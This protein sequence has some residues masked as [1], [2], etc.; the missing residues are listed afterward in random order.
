MKQG[1]LL[2]LFFLVHSVLLAQ[3][4]IFIS[5]GAQNIAKVEIE[6]GNCSKQVVVN[7]STSLSDITLHPNGKMYGVGFGSRKVYEVNMTNGSLAELFTITEADKLVGMTAAKDGTIYITEGNVIPS[8]LY[9]VDVSNNT[10]SS[11]GW[12]ADGSAGDLS[13]YFGNLYN[14]SDNNKLV[15]VNIN[16][17]ANSTVIGSF[18]GDLG[19]ERIFALVT[20]VSGC[21]D[22]KTYGFSQEGN[23]FELNMATAQVSR[24]CDDGSIDLFGATSADEFDASECFITLDLDENDNSGVTGNNFD[25]DFICQ[26]NRNA[27]VADSDVKI[28]VANSVDSVVVSLLSGVLNGV[29]EFFIIGSAPN[30]NSNDSSSILTGINSGSATTGNFE[31]FLNTMRFKNLALP[32]SAGTRTV[33]V[34]AYSEGRSDT[35]FTTIDIIDYTNAGTSGSA[36]FCVNDA[37]R[38]LITF[39]GDS[40]DMGGIWQPV[41][42]S[43][44]GVFDPAIDMSGIYTYYVTD[45]CFIDSAEV[46][47]SLANSNSFDLGNDT[48]ICFA[49]SYIIDADIGN[50]NASYVWNTGSTNSS[51][52][53]TTDGN[54]SVTIDLGGCQVQ[55]DIDI[56]F[57]SFTLELG[58]DISICP[59]DTVLIGQNIGIQGANYSWNNGETTDE[60]Y[61]SVPGTYT[62]TAEYQTCTV[63]DMIT[64]NAATSSNIPVDLGSDTTICQGSTLILNT[65]YSTSNYNHMWSDGSTNESLSITTSGTYSVTVSNDCASGTGSVQVIVDDCDTTIIPIDTIDYNICE[66]LMP[67]AFSPNGDNIN[68]YFGPV[69]ECTGFTNYEIRIYNRFGELVFS[70][71]NAI[72]DGT[73]KGEQAPMDNFIWYAVF[74]FSESEDVIESGNIMLL[75]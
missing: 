39:L 46:N 73:Y 21:D 27:L 71:E 19:G 65:G 20:T 25:S 74:H 61:V 53:V 16:D 62:L 70:G 50:P 4:E 52:S 56:E 28:E 69:N 75:R 47:V 41:L 44:T 11:N 23:Y 54:F 1:A 14:A 10:Y 59:G 17:P 42:N 68:D 22:S 31:Q 55:D 37:P 18:N 32:M 13:W 58:N 63:Q 57:I 49:S 64:I 43:N 6:A 51:I 29:D 60:I 45:G 24:L 15:K 40:P 38:D 72:W 48:S 5:D 9:S 3:S 8:R 34:I 35:G 30:I 12:L 66:I 2:I 36:S 7:T 26:P 33:Q 67:N